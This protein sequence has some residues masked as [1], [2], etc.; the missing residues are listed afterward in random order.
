MRRQ[1]VGDVM[2]QAVV[3]AYQNAK[4]REIARVMVDREITAMPV[5]DKRHRVIGVVSETDL[6]AEEATEHPEKRHWPSRRRGRRSRGTATTAAELMTTPAVTVGPG[7]TVVQAARLLG[8]HRLKRLP[9]VD[10]EGR[11][12]GIVSQRDLLRVFT[13]TDQEIR[14]EI[15]TEVFTRL[16]PADPAAVSVRVSHGVVTLSGALPQKDLVPIAVRLAAATEGVVGVIDELSHVG[17]DDADA[18]HPSPERRGP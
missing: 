10:D 7:T 9:V 2:T 3:S 5:I 11:L 1:T 18:V 6:V 15:V 8:L 4:F 13:R 17:D 16:L 12:L 14:D